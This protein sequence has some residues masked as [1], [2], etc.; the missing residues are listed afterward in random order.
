[1]QY[2]EQCRNILEAN[3]STKNY[4]TTDNIAGIIR[5]IKVVNINR[6]KLYKL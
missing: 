5:A 4:K 2:S 3:S 1:M 6:S